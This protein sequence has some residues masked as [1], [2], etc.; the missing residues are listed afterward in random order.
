MCV[1]RKLTEE[2]SGSGNKGTFSM[3]QHKHWPKT[4]CVSTPDSM[5]MMELGPAICDETWL[6]YRARNHV[7]DMT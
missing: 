6:N 7:Y 2:T 3:C 5:R 4:Q 1:Y